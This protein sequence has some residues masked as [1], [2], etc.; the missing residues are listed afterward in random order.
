MGA[1]E[2]KAYFDSSPAELRGSI[3]AVV[4]ELVSEAGA[5]TIGFSPTGR[6]PAN[7][8]QAA[9]ENVQLQLNSI[10]LGNVPE[11]SITKSKL[12]SDVHSEFSAIENKFSATTNKI[13]ETASALAAADATNKT[14]LQNQ[15]NAHTNG[16]N[17]INYALSLKTECIFGRF[18]GNS[19]PSQF[20]DIGFTP[21]AILLMTENGLM[22][23]S[24]SF[25]GGLALLNAP[26][27]K[28]NGQ[29]IFEIVANGLVCY[30]NTNEYI[31]C[32]DKN[33]TLTYIAFK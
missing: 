13:N 32:N 25:Q 8:V 3:N 28:F 31:Y 24:G 19:Q 26:C 23:D 14:E 20:I 11:G 1:D 29:K 33:Y 10:A 4:D 18:K 7:T 9:I 27:I 21:K 5:K 22:A 15:I 2:I 17:A 30:L 16:I 12:A 6:V